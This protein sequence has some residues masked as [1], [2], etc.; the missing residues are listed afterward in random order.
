MF[1]REAIDALY[2]FKSAAQKDLH[3][4]KE[5]KSKLFLPDDDRIKDKAVVKKRQETF[6]SGGTLR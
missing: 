3:P 5:F 1:C 6:A 4:L 2:E